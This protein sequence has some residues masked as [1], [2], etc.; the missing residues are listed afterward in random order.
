MKKLTYLFSILLCVI[1]LTACLPDVP[2]CSK[3]INETKILCNNNWNID[4]IVIQTN[5]NYYK[6]KT[7]TISTSQIDGTNFNIDMHNG[8]SNLV[9]NSSFRCSNN[10]GYNDAN[11]NFHKNVDT[12]ITNTWNSYSNIQNNNF[13][14][15]AHVM[16]RTVDTTREYIQE[17]NIYLYK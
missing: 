3:A 14:L 9:V 15:Y 7:G 2:E 8:S 12:T 17:I 16:G 4:S 1:Y 11:I 13:H 5:R 6:Y 10:R